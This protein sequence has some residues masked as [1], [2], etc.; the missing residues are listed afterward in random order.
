MYF[1][2]KTVLRAA[3]NNIFTKKLAVKPKNTRKKQKTT[4]KSISYFSGAQ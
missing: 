1:G 2:K 3:E 4:R